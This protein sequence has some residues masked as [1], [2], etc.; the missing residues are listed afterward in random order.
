MP[1][2]LEAAEKE[3]VKILWVY[4]NYCH[5]KYTAL[6][7]LQATHNIAEPLEALSKVEQNKILFEIS[8][9]IINALKEENNQVLA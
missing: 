6:K 1:P 9:E 4:L 2:L 5:Y 8:D 3:G 7:N